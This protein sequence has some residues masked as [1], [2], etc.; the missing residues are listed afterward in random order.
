VADVDKW[1]LDKSLAFYKDR[2]SDASEF[3]FVFVG[4]FNLQTMK[5]LVERY[6]GSLPAT[7]RNETWKDVGAKLPTGVIEKRVEKGI[8]PK[9]QTAIVFTGPFEYDPVHRAA[10]R[11]MTQILQMRLLE[12]IR[13]ELGGTYSIT[14]NASAEKYPRPEYELAIQFGSDPQRT[15]DLVKQVF[16]EIDKLR[17]QGPEEKQLSDE[18]E[19][20][21][22]EF[23]TSS[24]QNGYLVS[25]I[26]G[27]I[28][29]GE[30][31]AG[32]WDLP[33][34]YKKLDVA[35]VQDAAKKYLNPNNVIKVSLFPEKK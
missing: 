2:F 3:T 33:E 5:P 10:L 25:Q 8:E 27:K 11:A 28:E 22:R 16:S 1:N 14:A 13:E 17:T 15:D 21:Q 18:K 29:S 30:D 6:L 23:E 20:L 4:S 34:L 35:T 32:I 24:K 7:H 9:S 12:S 19:A 31:I 26:V